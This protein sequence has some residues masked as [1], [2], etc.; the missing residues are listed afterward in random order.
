MNTNTMYTIYDDDDEDDDGV[1]GN[2]YAWHCCF[3]Y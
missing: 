3:N 1:V 2:E